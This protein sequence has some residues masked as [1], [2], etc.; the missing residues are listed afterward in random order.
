VNVMKYHTSVFQF[1]EGFCLRNSDE[2]E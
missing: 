2:Y 1:P